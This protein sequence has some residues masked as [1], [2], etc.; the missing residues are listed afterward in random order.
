MIEPERVKEG[1]MFT[2]TFNKHKKEKERMATQ[3]D[4]V[5][6]QKSN[7]VKDGAQEFQFKA[8]KAGYPRIKNG[9]T[10]VGSQWKYFSVSI[11][12]KKSEDV[13][14]D[15]SDSDGDEILSHD[16]D[17]NNDEVISFRK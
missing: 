16:C 15:S 3:S 1:E 6:F 10:F 11:Q 4:A 2:I 7:F 12:D 13:Y 5:H 9:V 8:L 14:A 17:N